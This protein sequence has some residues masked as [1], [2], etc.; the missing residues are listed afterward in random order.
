VKSDVASRADDW[1]ALQAAQP[2]RDFALVAPAGRR[3]TVDHANAGGHHFGAGLGAAESERGG[4]ASGGA[5]VDQ[6]APDLGEAFA[7]RA[8]HVGPGRQLAEMVLAGAIGDSEGGRATERGNDRAVDR[9]A[10]FVEHD[11]V[12]RAW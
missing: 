1:K 2:P 8:H 3:V 7:M 12:D 9:S 11:A 10:G 6:R 5:N 4:G